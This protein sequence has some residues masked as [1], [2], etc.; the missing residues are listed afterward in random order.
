MTL[1]T[2][3]TSCIFYAYPYKGINASEIKEGLKQF[4]QYFDTNGDETENLQQPVVGI[5]NDMDKSWN[6]IRIGISYSFFNSENYLNGI[7]ATSLNPFIV[8][9]GKYKRDRTIE[10]VVPTVVVGAIVIV[11]IIV[12]VV[13]WKKIKRECCGAPFDD[14]DAMNI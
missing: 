7:V 9:I 13:N 6:G 8:L 1:Y 11:T 5:I 12:I 3:R 2:A 14:E 4:I 10:I